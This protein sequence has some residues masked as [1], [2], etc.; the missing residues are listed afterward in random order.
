MKELHSRHITIQQK[1]EIG[2]F[3][4]EQHFF[5]TTIPNGYFQIVKEYSIL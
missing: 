1:T 3:Y 4:Q 5:S 2:F